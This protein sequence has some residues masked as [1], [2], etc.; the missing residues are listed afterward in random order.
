M[1]LDSHGAQAIEFYYHLLKPFEHYVPFGI[2]TEEVWTEPRR[3]RRKVRVTTNITAALKAA[4][5]DDSGSKAIAERASALMH[6]HLC[7]DA[8]RCYMHRLLMRYGRAMAYRPDLSRRPRA[9]KIE[10]RIQLER[11][12]KRR[13]SKAP[14]KQFKSNLN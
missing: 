4:F 13:R 1:S 6:T 14:K 3:H 10:D 5:A 9:V 12:D 11:V 8:R 7:A 2:K